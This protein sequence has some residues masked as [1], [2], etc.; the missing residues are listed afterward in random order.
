MPGEVCEGNKAT[1][2]RLLRLLHLIF[3][4][5]LK[6]ADKAKVLKRDYDLVL[7]PVMS[8]KQA[9]D[10]LMIPASEQKKY[11]PQV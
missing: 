8:A 11:A 6:A 1:K 4:D 7:T 2:H 3:L 5:K 9:M 10:A